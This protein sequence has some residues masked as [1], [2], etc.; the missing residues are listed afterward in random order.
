MA[1]LRARLYARIFLVLAVPLLLVG[2]ATGMMVTTWLQRE[3]DRTL[4]TKARA[5]LSLTE[6]DGTHVEFDFAHEVMP[7]FAAGAN[8]QYFEMWLSKDR[9][10]QR[11]E[12]FAANETTRAAQLFRRP[13]I[14]SRARFD[15]VTLPDGRAGRQVR[16]DF[17][18]R[19]D[20]DDTTQATAATNRAAEVPQGIALDPTEVDR[21][22]VVSVIVAREREYLDTQIHALYALF[23]A[24]A[25]GLLTVLALLINAML[26]T[27]LR[28]LDQLVQQV[29]DIG[30]E[31]FGTRI[32]V[33]HPPAEIAPVVDQLNALLDRVDI[34]FRRERQLTSDLAHELKTPIAELR[35]L[36]DIGAR[37]P[38]DTEDVRQFFADA[39]GV[40]G[41]MERIVSHLLLMARHES[42]MQ[43]LQQETI[44]VRDVIDK[45]WKLCARESNRT[46]PTLQNA[47]SD[48][49]VFVSDPVLFESIVCNV[50]ANAINYSVPGSVVRCSF[51]AYDGA[52]SLCVA[53]QAEDLE[54]EDVPFIFDRFW[55]KD[56][57]RGGSAHLGLGLSLAR[58]FADL[59]QFRIVA[60][61]DAERTFRIRLVA[62]DANAPARPRGLAAAD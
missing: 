19:T 18:P 59:L 1:S 5:L 37:W 4:E 54:P 39:K 45:S 52:P 21:D 36:C 13:S 62:A 43:D 57:V 30:S 25:L 11:S 28:P 47:V 41:V 32:A 23:A 40:A 51:E 12:S 35:N 31:T 50:L 3:F 20:E 56:A 15:E 26:R 48:S 49:A 9:L 58:T 24:V 14:A 33:D 46:A 10:L 60:T 42:G 2:L 8:P 34:A 7:E 38:N 17:V 6:Q 22:R 16:I 27:V 29:R 44:R 55:R 61:L 53:N